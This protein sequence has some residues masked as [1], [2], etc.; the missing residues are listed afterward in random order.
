MIRWD[1]RTLIIYS[2]DFIETFVF[3]LDLALKNGKNAYIEL[4]LSMNEAYQET[5]QPFVKAVTERDN[6]IEKIE[7]EKND[8]NLFELLEEN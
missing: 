8:D 2:D 5:L 7:G 6:F 3:V 4:I 1:S